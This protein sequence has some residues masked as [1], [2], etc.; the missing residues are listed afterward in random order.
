MSHETEA[1]CL[2]RTGVQYGR[3]AGLKAGAGDPIFVGVK[4]G[5]LSIYFGDE[6]I[7]HF[8]LEGRWQRAY[9]A[10]IHYRK[11]LDG[12]IDAIDRVRE[13][14]NMVLQRR[15]LRYSEAV[16]LDDAVR[17]MAL[18]LLDRLC[19]PAVE[20]IDPPEGIRGFATDDLR[21]HLDRVV[22]WNAAVWFADRERY[23]ATYGALPFI[24]PDAMQSVILQATLGHPAGNAFG[25]EP[26]SSTVARSP[27]QFA[28]H[29]RAV[30]AL[31]GRRAAQARSIYLAGPDALRQPFDQVVEY[32][33]IAGELFPCE[34][35]SSRKN[36]A[37]DAIVLQ[38]INV[39]LHDFGP[40][41][42][43]RARW[44][45]LRSLHLQRVNLGV[46]SA[47]AGLRSQFGRAWSDEDLRKLAADA[48]AAGLDL[49]VIV[50]VG[51]EE[52]ES[53]AT[54][55]SSLELGK[56]DLVYLVYRSA[57]GG[58]RASIEPGGR[59]DIEAARSRLKA[60]L[61]PLHAERGVKVVSYN[62]E[63]EW[64]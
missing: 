63:K 59:E 48:R 5:T 57:L 27:E 19:R 29:A 15:S 28:E 47:D 22:R 18:G 31:L 43:D 56:G 37:E 55:L 20:M 14:P 42:P 24:P 49:G 53:A 62:P 64:H 40:P 3:R 11:A 39:F 10:G 2:L 16:D 51:A 44:E 9:I 1:A 12:S 32:F 30:A 6:P 46:E 25:G 36:R 58:S 34:C 45:R 41:L 61:E 13:G 7:Y 21:E 4:Q 8:D 50:L 35:A 17:S 60:A 52:V 38:G 26:A 23:V 54:L 33:R